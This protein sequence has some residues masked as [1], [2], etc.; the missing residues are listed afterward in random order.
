M[1][2]VRNPTEEQARKVMALV[3]EYSWSEILLEWD[4]SKAVPGVNEGEGEGDDGDGDGDGSGVE[5][6][7][8]MMPTAAPAGGSNEFRVDFD[9]G[10]NTVHNVD[11]RQSEPHVRPPASEVE[12]AVLIQKLLRARMARRE[13][14]K[15][16]S[17]MFEK[18]S[19]MAT[20]PAGWHSAG[21]PTPAYYMIN[22][23][24]CF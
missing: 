17:G 3:K 16:A 8:F 2:I 23:T 18:V 4:E 20:N 6:G 19:R 1:A 5:S 11:L 7:P 14:R 15:V 21:Q 24:N 12:A 13:V 10:P 9:F 22:V